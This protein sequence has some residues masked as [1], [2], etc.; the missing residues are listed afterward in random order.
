MAHG[1]VSSPPS[2]STQWVP[3]HQSVSHVN[4]TDRARPH[5]YPSVELAKPAAPMA[6]S[7]LRKWE[8]GGHV[9]NGGTGK[10]AWTRTGASRSRR[11]PAA[12]GSQL[13]TSRVGVPRDAAASRS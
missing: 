10:L 12:E 5:L 7:L 3:T 1:I 13:P 2:D 9:S 11:G 4:L 8:D 6:L